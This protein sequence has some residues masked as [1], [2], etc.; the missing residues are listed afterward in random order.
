[1][2]ETK[3]H[4]ELKTDGGVATITL[5]RPER[6]NSLTPDMVRELVRV[7][8][9]I[10]MRHDVHVVVLTGTGKFFCT[11][12]DL[13]PSNQAELSGKMASGTQSGF[14]HHPL[15]LDLALC[16]AV[17][18]IFFFFEVLR[19]FIWDFLYGCP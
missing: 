5:T 15:L 6:G 13:T 8:D 17:H 11:G 2:S 16:L 19:F 3:K 12:M 7:L 18:L 10:K 1:M 14:L 9:F 4:V